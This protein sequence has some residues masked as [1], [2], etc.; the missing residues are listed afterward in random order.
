MTESEEW[1]QKLMQ[2]G[3]LQQNLAWLKNVLDSGQLQQSLELLRKVVDSGQQQQRPEWLRKTV[4][5]GPPQ[6]SPGPQD[7]LAGASLA[8][9]ALATVQS[10]LSS[11]ASYSDSHHAAVRHS[12]TSAIAELVAVMIG[13]GQLMSNNA[14]T[15]AP[16]A[17]TTFAAQRETTA[18]TFTSQQ[19][20]VV[21]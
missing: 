6:Q 2:S 5:S 19:G 3:Q 15:R 16:A 10:L 21:T 18:S 13:V 17:A 1:I 14:A 11:A 20:P 7:L 9:A 4:D 12:N 8:G